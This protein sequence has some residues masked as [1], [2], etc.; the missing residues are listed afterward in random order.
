MTDVNETLPRSLQQKEEAKKRSRARP[1]KPKPS[2]L[3]DLKEAKSTIVHFW[4]KAARAAFPV[5]ENNRE[6]MFRSKSHVLTVDTTRPG[7]KTLVEYLRNSRRNNLEWKERTPGQGGSDGL[8]P[9]DVLEKLMEMDSFSIFQLFKEYELQELG[10]SPTD[11]K[12]EMIS[13]FQ[14]LNKQL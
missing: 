3:K 11:S 5:T 7:A 12:A 6:F 13:G 8:S 9:A 14:K 1:S 4:T 10:L 2:E